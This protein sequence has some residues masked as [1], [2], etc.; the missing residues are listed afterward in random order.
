MSDASDSGI[1]PE[2][3]ENRVRSAVFWRSGSQI[4]SQMVMWA[5]T[6]VVIRLL[7][8]ADYGL[9]AMTQVVMALFNVMNGYSFA[10]A[11]VQAPQ[12]DERRV[13]QVLGMLILLNGG[14]AFAQIAIA[15]LAAAYYRQPMIAPLLSV[16]ALLFLLNPFIALPYA[17]LSRSLDFRKQA[18]VNFAAALAGAATSLGCAMAGL[19][20]WTL[21]AA[22]L[23]LFGTRAIGLTVAARQ[24]V[25]PSFRFSGAGATLGFGA[26]L[27]LGQ[28]F[29]IVQTQADVLI[30]GRVL[31]PHALGLYAEALFLALIF[32][33][34]FVPPLNEVAFPAYAHIQHDRDATARGFVKAAG[35]VMLAACPLYLGLAVT[36]PNVVE[37]LF[38]PKWLEMA[39]LVTI[40][41]LAMPFTTL[42]I[43][44]APATNGLGRPGIATRT[45]AAGA[46]VMPLCFLIGIR[47]GA[48][49][50][51]CA[52]LVGMPLLLGITAHQSLPLIGAGWRDLVRAVAPAAM[53]AI[54]M[55]LLV[56]A[57]QS[58]LPPLP[59]VP[60][61]LLLAGIGVAAYGGLLLAFARPT[62]NEVIRIARRRPIAA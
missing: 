43:L 60:R 24:L 40:I 45:A 7:N 31:G 17:L 10:S 36:A 4:L 20:V 29:W 51:A 12:L 44:F 13:A 49:G 46:I 33:S 57:F 28:L 27:L 8:P 41:A 37:A 3:I 52:W 2:S 32:T 38:G 30:A 50:L 48:T 47:W 56:L 39:P 42:Q 25:R 1:G 18:K 21:V 16:Q 26:A 62:L 11:L 23:A 59:A 19:G 58:V 5:S 22:P 54:G 55:A 6:L 35:F 9:F 15:P 14:L 34:K 61:L 53:A